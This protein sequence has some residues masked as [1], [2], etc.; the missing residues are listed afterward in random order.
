MCV[1]YSEYWF[2]HRGPSDLQQNYN[3]SIQQNILYM[4]QDVALSIHMQIFREQHDSVR[5]FVS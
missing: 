5:R 4:R 1:Y 3:I 2:E